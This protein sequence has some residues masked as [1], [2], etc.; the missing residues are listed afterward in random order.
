MRERGKKGEGKEK[1]KE[2]IYLKTL[3]ENNTLVSS[4]F[5]FL[6]LNYFLILNMSIKYCYSNFINEKNGLECHNC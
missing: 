1:K 5:I 2:L 6:F 4:M 3:Y